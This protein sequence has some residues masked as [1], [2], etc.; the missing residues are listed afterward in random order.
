MGIVILPHWLI[1]KIQRVAVC[2]VLETVTAT[3]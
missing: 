3:R 1:E 2:K